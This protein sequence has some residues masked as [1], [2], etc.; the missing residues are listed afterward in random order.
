MHFLNGIDGW[1]DECRDQGQIFCEDI[2]ILKVIFSRRLQRFCGGLLLVCGVSLLPGIQSAMAGLEQ[3]VKAYDS[4]DYAAAIKEW[5]PEAEKGDRNALFNLGQIYRMGKGVQQNLDRAEHYYL[6][7][8]KRGHPAAQ[9]NLG[10]LYYFGKANG[11]PQTERALKWWRL[12]AHSGDPRSQ[13]ML[14]VL[15]FNGKHVDRDIVAAYGWMTLAAKGG[16]KEADEAQKK[17]N[18][19]LASDEIVAGKQ[20]AQT[21]TNG[22]A[23]AAP[24]D[25]SQMASAEVKMQ[26]KPD[27]AVMQ[28]RRALAIAAK[29]KEKEP[30]KRAPAVTQPAPAPPTSLATDS[31]PEVPA[32][33][34]GFL[35]QLG[36]Y[37]DRPSVE[38]SW[39]EIQAAHPAILGALSLY[40]DE[41][42]LGA[43]GIYYRLQAGPF[44]ARDAA[45]ATC[46]RLKAEKQD[47]LAVTAK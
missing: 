15:Y 14:G 9:G 11:K 17:M 19:I 31:A 34:N 24:V 2:W 12:A 27:N 28:R 5:E 46:R 26:G 43:K 42:D 1:G 18:G 45:L 4:G 16:L 10:T 3:G 37:R 13:Y 36:S 25:D 40:V 44:A 35:V 47:C 22:P 41:A 32:A 39:K 38:A 20:L 21:L 6:E 23:P 29:E 30:E 7:A 33:A 8:A